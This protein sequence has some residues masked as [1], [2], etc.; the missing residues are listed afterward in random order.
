M[1][2][3]G[4]QTWLRPTCLTDVVDPRLPTVTPRVEAADL[5]A[6][7]GAMTLARGV[8]TISGRATA[9]G[10]HGY[11]AAPAFARSIAR[12]GAMAARR[13]A[14][15]GV[16]DRAATYVVARA[17]AVAELAASRPTVPA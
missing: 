5:T 11:R 16:V 8:E 2:R 7:G 1:P 12:V 9:P 13:S 4:I 6:R 15:P 10:F 14:W 17:I 3:L